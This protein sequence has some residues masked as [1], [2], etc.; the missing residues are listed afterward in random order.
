MKHQPGQAILTSGAP[1]D[2]CE[3][4]TRDGVLIS[5]GRTMRA[6]LLCRACFAEAQGGGF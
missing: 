4:A 3:K 5:T 2:R 6:K 1:C